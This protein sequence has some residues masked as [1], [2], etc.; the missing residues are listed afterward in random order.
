MSPDPKKGFK[1]R[2]KRCPYCST[3]LALHITT[4][5]GCGKK[6]GHVDP[7]GRAKTLVDWKG[8]GYCLAA[9]ILF[10]LFIWWAFF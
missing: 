3:E 1:F 7:Q 4:C 9:W 6:V 5:A 8:Y 10:G 2:S